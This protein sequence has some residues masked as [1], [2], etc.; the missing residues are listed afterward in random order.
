MS[1]KTIKCDK[2]INLQKDGLDI[3]DTMNDNGFE[4]Y[5]VGGCVRDILLDIKPHDYDFCTNAKPED[6]IRLFEHTIPTGIKFGTVTIVV[7]RNTYEMTTYRAESEYHDSRHPDS[8]EFL[9]SLEE[10]LMRRDFTINAIA[11]HPHEGFLSLDDSTEDDIKE[12]IICCVGDP[13]MRFMEDS[14]R[15]LRALRFSL[16]YGFDI[17]DKTFKY[18]KLFAPLLLNVAKER[19]YKELKEIFDSNAF[20]VN[21]SEYLT[22]LEPLFPFLNTTNLK[23]INHG[24]K[25]DTRL[26]EF[27]DNNR[28][29]INLSLLLSNTDLI[30]V[31]NREEENIVKFHLQ[32]EVLEHL[33]LKKIERNRIE[34]ILRYIWLNHYEVDLNEESDNLQET[35]KQLQVIL[36]LTGYE[37]TMCLL[38]LLEIMDSN[39]KGNYY[40]IADLL[41]MIQNASDR[42]VYIQDLCINGNDIKKYGYEGKKIKD[43]LNDILNAIYEK[44]ISNEKKSIYAWLEKNKHDNDIK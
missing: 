9:G 29:L 31:K 17:E 24:F 41:Y 16:R 42:C 39:S 20:L 4:C 33:K 18:M 2:E 1:L 13:R 27:Y 32:R 30:H 14:I 8:I 7:G 22:I 23:K 26:A 34:S 40:I 35:L 25:K 43:T 15:I 11:Y 38:V 19:L 6:V 5:L 37:T 36:R 28:F 21:L 12:G 10:D 44:E 3:I